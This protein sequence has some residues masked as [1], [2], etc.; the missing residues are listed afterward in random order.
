[1]RLPAFREPLFTFT[2]Q[3]LGES[4]QSKYAVGRPTSFLNALMALRMIRIEAM[5]ISGG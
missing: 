3:A 2:E 4:E 5:T 1:L